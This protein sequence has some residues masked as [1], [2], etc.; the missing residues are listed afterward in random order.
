MKGWDILF[1]ALF[2]CM[3]FPSCTDDSIKIWYD[4]ASSCW[5]EALPIGN[6]SI[7]AMIY[8]DPEHER[9]QLNEETIWAGSPYNNTNPAAKEHLD[10]IRELISGAHGMPYQTAGS[11][12]LDFD[13]DGTVTGYRREL[14]LSRAVSET[15][16]RAGGT[17]FLREYF[18][19]FPDHVAVIRL[20]ASDKGSVTFNAAYDSP[21]KGTSV[22]SGDGKLIL[23][24][25]GYDWE[26]VKGG[27]SYDVISEIR[28]M[29][30]EISYPDESTVRVTDADEVLIFISI[31]TNFIRYDDVS[32]DSGEVSPEY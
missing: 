30:G 12:C 5:E 21:M 3:M 6:G 22:S 31:G 17:D 24:G 29:G 32:G 19:S 20:S 28:N 8:G 11:L 18:V 1:V 27:I 25:K 13:L 7:G 14:D 26:G 15:R 23:S 9:I 16:F 10:E 4:E 2:S